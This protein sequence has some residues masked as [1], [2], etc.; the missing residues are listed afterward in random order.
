MEAWNRCGHPK[1][2]ENSKRVGTSLR[3][4]LA[5]MACRTC[6]RAVVRRYFAELR[7]QAKA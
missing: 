6:Q 5:K 4:G 1:T 7:E 3:T 2:P